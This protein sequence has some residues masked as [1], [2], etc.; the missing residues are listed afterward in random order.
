MTKRKKSMIGHDP[1]AW[2]QPDDDMDEQEEVVVKPKK[3]KP[4]AKKT[5]SKARAKVKAKAIEAVSEPHP[6][7]I[8][9]DAFLAGFE[10]VKDKIADVASDFYEKLFSDYPAVKPLF[11][12]VDFEKQGKKLADTIGVV[13]NNINDVDKLTSVLTGLGA[14]HQTYGVK[15]E[16]YS[17]VAE[18]LLAVLKTH[19]G[20]KWTKKIANNWDAVLNIAAEVMLAAYEDEVVV[21][22]IHR[23][24]DGSKQDDTAE[25]VMSEQLESVLMLDEV[26]DISMASN[27]HDKLKEQLRLKS[28]LL[29]IDVSQ[30]V[31]I[32][33]SCLQLLHA[34]IRDADNGGYTVKL[35]GVSDAFSYSVKLLGLTNSIKLAA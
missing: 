16:H 27:L 2:I 21:E 6:L 28:K 23:V 29:V 7:G 25:N 10:L 22:Q 34:V 3:T 32:D 35:Q 9:V 19:G 14:R 5:K 17:A 12:D 30:V 8:D 26:Q 20:R 11:T 1:L 33:A 18:S 24:E 13:A 31:R 15:Q 4:A